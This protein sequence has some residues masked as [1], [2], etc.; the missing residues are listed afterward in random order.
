M[1]WQHTQQLLL[2]LEKH[3]A[4]YLAGTNAAETTAVCAR[5]Q[6]AAL[7]TCFTPLKSV[8]LH[9]VIQSWYQRH[10]HCSW[11][12]R[13]QHFDSMQVTDFMLAIKIVLLVLR[14]DTTY[15]LTRLLL[16]LS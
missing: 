14:A 9:R 12:Q 5:H 15:E 7:H 13:Y 4:A 11:Y 3:A 16:Q 6:N 10:Q 8:A 2:V 1:L